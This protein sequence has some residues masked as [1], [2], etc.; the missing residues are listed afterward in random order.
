[1]TAVLPFAAFALSAFSAYGQYKAGKAQ[2][3]GLARQATMDTIAARGKALEARAQGLEALKAINR[4][5]SALNA[6]AA[7]GGIDPFSGSAAGLAMYNVSEGAREYFISQDNQIILREGGE[8]GAQNLLAQA[9]SAK[10][11]GLYQAA[12]TLG[13]ASMNLYQ[14]MKPSTATT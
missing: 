1:M 8:I 7:A 13:A 6:R 9:A 11:A 3:K 12:G 2:A 10:Q 14:T 4:T 5:N